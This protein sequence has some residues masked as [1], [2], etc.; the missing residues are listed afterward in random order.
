MADN[1]KISGGDRARNALITGTAGAYLGSMVLDGKVKIPAALRK[2]LRTRRRTANIHGARAGGVAGAV[3]GATNKGKRSE[4]VDSVATGGDWKFSAFIEDMAFKSLPKEV[5]AEVTRFVDAKA[6]TPLVHYG[7]TVTE[8]IGKADAENLKS[9]R[10]SLGTLRA[11]RA[12]EEVNGKIK[13]GSKYILLMNDRIV[14][15]HH[16]L[17]KAER[18]AITSSLNVLDLTPARLSTGKTTEFA[19]A[20]KLLKEKEGEHPTVEKARYAGRT[21]GMGV[22]AG[23]AGV[24]GAER[25]SMASGVQGMKA[26]VDHA[27][28]AMDEDFVGQVQK[29]AKRNQT[30][31]LSPDEMERYER[32]VMH[33]DGKQEVKLLPGKDVKALPSTAPLGKVEKGKPSAGKQ[34]LKQAKWKAQ[35]AAESA[36]KYLKRPSMSKTLILGGMAGSFVGGKIGERHGHRMVESNKETQKK[37][38]A[39]RVLKKAAEIAKVRAIADQL[40]KHERE[41]QM[42]AKLL[43]LHQFAET[44]SNR[45]RDLRDKLGL[46]K[47]VGTLGLIGGAGYGGHKL[48]KQGQKAVAE[49]TPAVRRTLARANVGLRQA[50][51]LGKSWR[52]AAITTKETL[53]KVAG[54]PLIAPVESMNRGLAKAGR[55]LAAVPKII[56]QMKMWTH[57]DPRAMT[58]FE[59]APKRD[60]LSQAR[61]IAVLGGAAAATG[62]AGYLVHQGRKVVKAVAPAVKDVKA[63]TTNVRHATRI[64]ADM[65]RVYGDLTQPLRDPKRWQAKVRGGFRR[66]QRA[67]AAAPAPGWAQKVVRIG[68]KIRLLQLGPQGQMKLTQFA[69]ID[70]SEAYG[71]IDSHTGQVM[72]KTTYAK[73]NVSRKVAERLGLKYG[74]GDRYRANFLKPQHIAAKVT[75]AVSGVH[76]SEFGVIGAAVGTVAGAM[77]GGKVRA[78]LY[79]A[80]LKRNPEKPLGKW[81]KRRARAGAYAVE[82]GAPAL[83]GAVGGMVGRKAQ[84]EM[85]DLRVLRQFGGSEQQADLHSGRYMDSWD[86]F[87]GKSKGYR[88]KDVNE[89]H[90]LRR[91]LA[92]HES[93]ARKFAPETVS[94]IHGGM[95]AIVNNPLEATTGQVGRSIMRKANTVRMVS[96]RG[97][98]LAADAVKHLRGD[99]REKDAWGREKKREWEKPWFQRKRNQ[100]VAGGAILATGL[101]YRKFPKL[102]RGVEGLKTKGKD[103]VNKVWADTFP[104]KGTAHA[105]AMT[106]KPQST[107]AMIEEEAKALAA[108]LAK[109]AKEA[110]ARSKGPKLKV[111]KPK[112]SRPIKGGDTPSLNLAAHLGKLTRFNDPL[113]A[114]WDLRDA[115]GRS[116]RVFAPGS[117]GR[118]RRPKEWYEKIDNERKLWAGAAL[119]GTGL[120]AAVMH[121]LGGKKL[122][123]A[124][125]RAVQAERAKI[126]KALQAVHKKRAAA[127]GPPPSNIRFMPKPSAGAA[128]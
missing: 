127:G 40:Y 9:A 78:P 96:E 69:V 63:T 98:G 123:G 93:G 60:K 68:K 118:E 83:G 17:A 21:A 46:A 100:L 102:Q 119:A 79:R 82:N 124:T 29:A 45:T 80:L 51:K 23:V 112:A 50:G 81:A 13:A 31:R 85:G 42:S 75:R 116:A 41:R 11:S 117:Q 107:S 7:M 64:G 12:W 25:G 57:A 95:K 88:K 37:M 61:D 111:V 16:F 47:D 3:L 77:L 92:D 52:K 71:V 101:A 39:N 54:S 87:I 86:S 103:A 106:G 44:P 99:K 43:G 49:L 104:D 48:Y 90:R 115:R 89:Y 67:A 128:A 34:V 91:Q 30:I 121:K 120:G 84:Q 113:D 70:P 24:I 5:Q 6:G 72:H 14:D 105:A 18:G 28:K 110:K 15:G 36:W 122:A 19:A 32:L 2:L 97:G 65:G 74:S 114:G 59:T 108:K 55:K 1:S 73:R 33:H 26:T 10:K 8:L 20:P 53:D 38:A 56:G 35:D 66:G 58:T 62:A 76:F 109:D 27:K 126:R 125:E 4:T 22:G 94:K